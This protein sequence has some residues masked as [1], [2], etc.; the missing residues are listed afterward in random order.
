[1]K[2]NNYILFGTLQYIITS[3]ILSHISEGQELVGGATRNKT[4][5]YKDSIN[6]LQVSANTKH[7]SGIISDIFPNDLFE[8]DTRLQGSTTTLENLEIN[9]LQSPEVKKL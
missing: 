8:D 4:K 2:C 5:C 1:M 6:R 3:F 7:G 9:S